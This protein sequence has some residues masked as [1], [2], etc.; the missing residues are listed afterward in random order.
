LLEFRERP[1]RG[2]WGGSG[3]VSRLD[4]AQHVAP[5]AGTAIARYAG[6]AA[7]FQRCQVQKINNVTEYLPERDRAAVKFRMR[8][9]AEWHRKELHKGRAG[10]PSRHGALRHAQQSEQSKSGNL[11]MP[12]RIPE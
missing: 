1:G 4:D 10:L 6:D 9:A 7:F 12:L 5:P 11:R 3:R 8:S 2:E